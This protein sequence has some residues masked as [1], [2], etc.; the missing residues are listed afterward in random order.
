MQLETRA[1]CHSRRKAAQKTVKQGAFHMFSLLGN[2]LWT[3]LYSLLVSLAYWFQLALTTLSPL[4]C[5]LMLE[6]VY[7]ASVWM[8]HTMSTFLVLQHLFLGLF[9]RCRDIACRQVLQ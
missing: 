4:G 2:L 3:P 9:D 5:G 8:P 1:S 6:E 7:I